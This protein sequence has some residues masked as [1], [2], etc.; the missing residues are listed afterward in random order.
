[1]E[2]EVDMEVDIKDLIQKQ[3]IK[4]GELTHIA[5]V[6]DFSTNKLTWFI[7]GVKTNQT[8]TKHNR[9]GKTS[10]PLKVGRGY[11]GI[12]F[13]GTF[14]NLRI[15]NRALDEMEIKALKNSSKGKVVK[16]GT[17]SI[18]QNDKGLISLSGVMKYKRNRVIWALITILPKY[19]PNRQLLFLGTQTSKFYNILVKPDGYI[20]IR[21]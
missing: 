13:K 4:Y 2:Q 21:N 6:R 10:W 11:T 15:H 17:P 9:A 18:T 8:K 16:Y 3:K 20:W 1:M 12:H 19:R 7:N 5:L 14:Y